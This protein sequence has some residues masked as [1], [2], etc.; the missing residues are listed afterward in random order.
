LW[1]KSEYRALRCETTAGAASEAAKDAHGDDRPAREHLDPGGYGWII[2]AASL[3]LGHVAANMAQVPIALQ[4]GIAV[5]VIASYAAMRK[6][7]QT[8]PLT[9]SRCLNRL[10][11]ACFL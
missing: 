7:R 4:S 2:A 3:V 9:V 8:N 11:L 10:S 6:V 1:L 5:A